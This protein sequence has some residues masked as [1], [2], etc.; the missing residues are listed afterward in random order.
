MISK[1]NIKK[2]YFSM[3]MFLFIFLIFLLIY[4][5]ATLPRISMPLI[6]SYIICLV[7][8]PILKSLVKLGINK[9]LS[10]IL[11]LVGMSFFVVYPVV[12]LTPVVKN[13]FERFQNYIPTVESYLRKKYSKA[14]EFVNNKTGFEFSDEYFNNGIEYTSKTLTNIL[15]HTPNILASFIEWLFL[16]PFL[17]FFILKDSRT[18]GKKILKLVPN[19]IFEKTYY[20]LHK[21][22]QQVGNYIFAKVV[23]ALIVG[24]IITSGLLILDVRFSL[25]LGFI[26]A[27]TN[28]V[29][30][31]GPVLGFVPAIIV[32]LIEHDIGGTLYAV[33]I[34]YSVANV[35]DL[36]FVFPLLVSRIVNLHPVI[37]VISV[38][39]GSQYMGVLGMI[40]SIPFA[41]IIKLMFQEIYSELYE[42]NLPIERDI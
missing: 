3:K 21:F 1:K 28:I 23:E 5:M 7:V 24:V 32:S 29:P 39:L 31:L 25:L 10:I 6:T 14:T 35:I 12:K 37:V 13:E 41:A 34:L 2:D 36:A 20:I 38:I 42:S 17:I 26:A 8:T 16:L 27:L 40:I 4:F 15:L 33:V 19:C 9:I 30:Y 11:L 18:L 22:N